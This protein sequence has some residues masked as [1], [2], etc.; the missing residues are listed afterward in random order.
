MGRKRRYKNQPRICDIDIIDYN[1]N[2]IKQKL[3]RKNLI[4]P[5][6]KMTKRNFVLFPLK[7][8]CSKWKHPKTGENI[9]NLIKKLPKKDH[10]SI[11]KINMN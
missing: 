5:H 4:I 8:I 6:H 11:L 3:N 2:I 7:Q 9:S 10:K 1:S